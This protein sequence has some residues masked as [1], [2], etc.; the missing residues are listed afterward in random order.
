[1]NGLTERSHTLIEVKIII[2][3]GRVL[4]C[5]KI[6]YNIEILLSVR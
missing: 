4:D 2:M 1:M 5:S 3:S 6:P